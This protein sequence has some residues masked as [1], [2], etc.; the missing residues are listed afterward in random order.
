MQRGES[1][2]REAAQYRGHGGLA[3]GGPV[4][5]PPEI[6][7]DL[8]HAVGIRIVGRLGGSVAPIVPENH[9]DPGLGERLDLGAPILVGRVQCAGQQE[10]ESGSPIGLAERGLVDL[11]I[12]LRAIAGDHEGHR[13]GQASRS[14]RRAAAI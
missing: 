6:V 13:R 2:K 12:E 4:Q 14:S 9:A 3:S 7:D 1:A 10:R 5:D 11:G 8:G